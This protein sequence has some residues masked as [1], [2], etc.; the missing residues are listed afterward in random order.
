[1]QAITMAASSYRDA[2]TTR[3]LKSHGFN[4]RP[5][6]DELIDYAFATAD[7]LDALYAALNLAAHVD[8]RGRWHAGEPL[9]PPTEVIAHDDRWEVYYD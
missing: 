8:V 1:K 7:K 3:T 5:D 9:P 4:Q 2:K 6:L